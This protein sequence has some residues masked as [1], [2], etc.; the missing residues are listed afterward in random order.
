MNKRDFSPDKRLL[1]KIEGRFVTVSMCA[2]TQKIA[3]TSKPPLE[4]NG[5]SLPFLY[6]G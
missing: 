1:P 4:M 3:R 6:L 5:P 2:G